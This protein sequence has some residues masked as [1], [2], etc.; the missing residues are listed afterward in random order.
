VLRKKL[1]RPGRGLSPR[2]MVMPICFCHRLP[3]YLCL[4]VQTGG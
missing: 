2:P 3:P 1:L 4:S